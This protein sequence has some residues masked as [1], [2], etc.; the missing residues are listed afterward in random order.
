[1]MIQCAALRRVVH[2]FRFRV[3]ES[4]GKPEASF[5]RHR[6]KD[7]IGFRWAGELCNL[8]KPMVEVE[9]RCFHCGTARSQLIRLFGFG[10]TKVSEYWSAKNGR[11]GGFV[12]HELDPEAPGVLRCPEPSSAR[13]WLGP[14]GF[15]N[16]FCWRDSRPSKRVN[17]VDSRLGGL[18]W[19]HLRLVMLLAG[20]RRL[21]VRHR[22]Q[23]VFFPGTL[24]RN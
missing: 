3:D 10:K 16:G 7:A 18:P 23:V 14:C 4:R 8:A 19:E 24:F 6:V 9:G 1:M 22:G 5:G 2:V 15:R 17:R 13:N 20:A 12:E 11:I 21:G